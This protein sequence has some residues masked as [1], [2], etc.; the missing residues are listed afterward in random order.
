MDVALIVAG[1][2]VWILGAFVLRTRM[3]M[4]LVSAVLALSG[5]A[6]G[7]G[8]LLLLEGATTAE[9]VVTLAAMAFIGGMEVR[10]LLGPF[11]KPAPASGTVSPR[12]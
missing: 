7:A 10:M 2:A 4:P 3:P 9:W 12:R 6:I 5:A 8:G 1:A 11:G